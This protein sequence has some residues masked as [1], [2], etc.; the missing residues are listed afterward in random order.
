LIDVFEWFNRKTIT[1]ITEKE[2]EA[3]DNEEAGLCGKDFCKHFEVNQ[4]QIRQSHTVS[5]E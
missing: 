5:H 2:T 1:A 3:T 4:N